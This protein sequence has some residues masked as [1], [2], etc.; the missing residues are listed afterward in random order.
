[1]RNLRNAAIAYLVPLAGALVMAGIFART[2]IAL[3]PANLLVLPLL[4][5]IGVNYGVQV[6]HDYRSQKGP[7]QISGHVFGTLVLTA[8]TSIAGFGSMMIASHR[9][10]FSLGIAL[11][12]GIASCLFVALIL[13]P[14]LLSV[15]SKSESVR[16]ASSGRSEN[17][18]KRS[19][20]PE[21]RAKAA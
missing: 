4:L 8:L 20:E 7:Y 19:A 15:I 13:V 14:S 11:A 16:S 6:V 9:G 1:M 17:S 12:I 18:S 2:H 21:R 3:N 5:G 10:L